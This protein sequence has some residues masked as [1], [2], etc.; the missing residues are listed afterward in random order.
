MIEFVIRQ[1][2]PDSGLSSPKQK[3]SICNWIFEPLS[4]VDSHIAK[5]GYFEQ[6]SRLLNIPIGA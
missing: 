2:L 6:I 4:E 5:E 3:E 1:K